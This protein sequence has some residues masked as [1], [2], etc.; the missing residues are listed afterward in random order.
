MAKKSK[1]FGIVATA[2][3]AAFSGLILLP[4]GFVILLGSQI[5]ALKGLLFTASG[6]LWSV[7]GVFALA[8]TYGL[9]SLQE[10]GRKGMFWISVITIPLGIVAMFPIWPSQQVTMGNI[11]LQLVG[12][13]ISGLIASYLS[14]Q[15]IRALF[16][17]A[18]A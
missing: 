6:V 5:P 13:A 1:P 15:R 16:S 10:W 14:R 2:I 4:T 9:W 18:E 12:I 3:Y 17:N 11:V 7:M 8:S